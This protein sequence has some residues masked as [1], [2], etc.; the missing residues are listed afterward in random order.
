MGLGFAIIFFAVVSAVLFGLTALLS[1]AVWLLTGRKH[2]RLA[3]W[4][5]AM[6]VLAGA[7]P[8][9]L[10]VGG[11]VWSNFAP[12]AARFEQV[13]DVK[14]SPR[15]RDLRTAG[16]GTS[17]AEEVYLA[18]TTDQTD[19]AWLVGPPFAKVPPPIEGQDLV[20]MPA[21]TPPAWWT[22]GRCANRTVH[23]ARNLR[24]WDDVVV[25]HCHDD[26]R[27]Y[28]QARWVD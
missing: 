10:L 28:V 16:S 2:R 12:P 9:L 25:T 1:L 5:I 7:A 18:F 13:F 23:R 22:A 17:D 20:P 4:L 26:G 3:P 21:E 24:Q 19:E 8:V 15:V 27:T 6:P 14:P 11:L